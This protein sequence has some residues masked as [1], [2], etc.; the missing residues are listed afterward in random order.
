VRRTVAPPAG[1]AVAIVLGVTLLVALTGMWREAGSGR[2]MSIVD[3]HVHLD[4][5]VRVHEGD[6]PHRGSLISMEVVR[7]WACGVG[8][9]GGATLA[10]CDSP[11]LAPESLPSGKF[12]SGYVHYPTYFVA[13][14]GYRALAE[15]LGGGSSFVDTY[16]HFAAL[17]M[18]LGM[19]VCLIAGWR[20]GLRGAALVA[21]TFAPSGT[22]AILLYGTIA[23]PQSASVLTGALVAWA[24][25]HLVRTGRGYGWLLAAVALTSTVSVIQALPAGAFILAM[26]A[27]LLLRRLGWNVP[28]SWQ[29]RWWQPVGLALAVVVPV[30]GFASWNAAR[31]T[32]SNDALYA[33]AASDGLPDLVHGAVWELSILHTPWYESTSLTAAADAPLAQHLLRAAAQGVPLWMTLAV[34]APLVVIA[35]G[36]VLRARHPGRAAAI[37]ALAIV[38]VATLVVLVLFPP[39]LRMRNALDVGIDY[40][41]VSRYAISFTPLLVWQLLLASRDRPWIARALAVLGTTAVLGVGAG[42][43]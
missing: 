27:V 26:A 9:E 7:E 6:Y 11:D 14:E 5:H 31:A 24:G 12:S 4:S 34:L 10:P 15:A 42:I 39:A 8:H 22:A 2:P 13:A 20:L 18:G 33:F 40:A 43:W 21:A 29:P 30:I 23:N 41:I 19:V 38:V 1:L 16:R 35:A 3:E 28:G 36:T 25:L 37:D 17:V 32:V